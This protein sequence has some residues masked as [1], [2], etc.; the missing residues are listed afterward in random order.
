MR[1]AWRNF[2]SLLLKERDV[3]NRPIGFRFWSRGPN[4]CPRIAPS[5]RQDVSLYWRFSACNL[6][7]L[8]QQTK[9]ASILM[10]VN[11]LLTKNVK[12][13]VL[14]CAIQRR[15]W[16]GKKSRRNLISRFGSDPARSFRN[17]KST[18]HQKLGSL[19]QPMTVSSGIYKEKIQS[20]APDIVS[21]LACPKFVFRIKRV[22]IQV[23]K[24]WFA[25]P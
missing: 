5:A 15:Q 9:F 7:A 24:R 4:C 16:F 22:G 10:M 21:S 23:T 2:L 6:M 8:D 12:M 25:K 11:F 3:D 13:I 17:I 1:G 20:L 18:T 14:A 19:G